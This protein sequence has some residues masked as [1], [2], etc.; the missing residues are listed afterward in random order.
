MAVVNIFKTK[1]M[2]YPGFLFFAIAVSLT[3]KIKPTKLNFVLLVLLIILSILNLIFFDS[4]KLFYDSGESQS[5]A[6]TLGN[7]QL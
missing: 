7:I 1:I 4:L 5:S 2:G 6:L 3:V